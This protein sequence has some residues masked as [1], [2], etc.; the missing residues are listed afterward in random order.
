[1]DVLQKY[2]LECFGNVPS[3]DLPPD[4]FKLCACMFDTPEFAK[5]YYLQPIKD[6]IQV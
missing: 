1:M 4:D 5:F 2:V 3:N 6:C